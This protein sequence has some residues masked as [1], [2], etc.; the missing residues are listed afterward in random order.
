MSKTMLIITV[1]LM[2]ILGGAELDLFIPSFPELQQQFS[3]TPFWVEMLLS[4]NFIG[5]C[6]GL[7]FVGGLADR[8]GRKPV[9]IGG[10][11]IFIIGSILCLC[12]PAYE[13]LLAGRFLQGLGVSA[14]GTLCFLII[15]DHYPLKE[16]QFMLAMLNGIVNAS[17][18]IA[19]VAGSY[20]TLAFRWQGNFVALLIMGLVVLL[21]TILFVP[22]SKFPE[23]KE[24]L[25]LRGYVPIFQNKSVMLMMIGFIFLFA[26]YWI[27]VGM[28]PLLYIEDLN[29]SLSHFGY[30]QGVFAA[31]FALGSMMVGFIMKKCDQA[32]ML[33]ISFYIFVFSLFT[34]AGATFTDTANP[35]LITLS[36]LPFVIGQIIPSVILY[37]IFLNKMPQAKGKVSALLR[38]G[39]LILTGFSLQLVGYFYAQSFQNIGMI[40][41][42]T[43]SVGVISLFFML[44]K[45]AV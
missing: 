2:D 31:I 8:Y 11:L 29:V 25:S 34:L 41:I 3:L 20:I 30:Y 5:I 10:L 39:N 45:T 37:P 12:A 33:K 19:P 28:S 36:F 7:F 21:M 26:P 44:K 43:I 38:M 4:I 17:I 6:L 22:P 23:E 35:L 13:V 18:G 32:K 40:L 16:Q 14:P 1:I 15:A 24:T 42:A 27:F 9:I